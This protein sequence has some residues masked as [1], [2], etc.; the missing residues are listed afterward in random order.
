MLHYAEDPFEKNHGP[1]GKCLEHQNGNTMS[2]CGHCGPI[3][4]IRINKAF[5]IGRIPKN[6]Q[7]LVIIL[8]CAFHFPSET[9]E[10]V[11]MT[12]SFTP[13]ERLDKLV[14]YMW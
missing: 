10:N 12:L 9:V 8:F 7:L 11:I 13:G 2:H 1:I 3:H 6:W 5:N 4:E 14:I